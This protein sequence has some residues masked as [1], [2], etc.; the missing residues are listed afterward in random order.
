MQFFYFGRIVIFAQFFLE[1]FFQNP[2]LVIVV[3][4]GEIVVVPGAA[5]GVNHE[6]FGQAKPQKFQAHGMERAHPVESQADLQKFLDT[7][8]HF[9]GGLVGK[10]HRQN[11]VR[12][13]LMERHQM[14]NLVGDG[15]R[16]ARTRPGQNQ[17][18]A[19][20][21]LGSRRLFRVQFLV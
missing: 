11:P 2:F 7:L 10:R 8:L 18:R 14:G 3:I 17:H 21:L 6:I 20:N 16:L 9:A 13:H 5:H 12:L 1:D 15:T 4:D 19:V